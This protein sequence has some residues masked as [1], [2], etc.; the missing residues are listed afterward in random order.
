M[1]APAETAE[2]LFHLVQRDPGLGA[3]TRQAALKL[4]ADLS[5]T[6]DLALTALRRLSLEV[7]RTLPREPA[8]TDLGRCVTVETFWRFHMASD[9]RAFFVTPEDYRRYIEGTGDPHWRLSEDLSTEGIAFPQEHSWLCRWDQIQDLD[10]KITQRILNL[11][12]RPPYVIF[13]LTRA[14]VQRAGITIRAARSVDAVLGLH[15]GWD[16]A[17]PSRGIVEYVDGD[18]PSTA[19]E[20]LEWRP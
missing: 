19:I 14:K 2:R 16:P 7:S 13:R 17:G 15:T 8:T 20:E 10:G 4:W 9:V 1:A 18:V 12:H 6:P 5:P 3:N 11:R